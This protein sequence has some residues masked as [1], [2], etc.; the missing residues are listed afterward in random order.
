MQ[1]LRKARWV[2]MAFLLS[3]IPVSSYAGV[4]IS[5]NIAPPVLPVYE[6]PPCPEPG[7]APE[8]E[9]TRP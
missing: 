8:P 9:N 4:L 5:V 6:Q 1:L 7:C 3:L 2:L